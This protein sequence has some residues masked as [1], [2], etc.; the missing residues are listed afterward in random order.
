[1]SAPAEG[2]GAADP[3]EGAPGPTAGDGGAEPAAR[4]EAPA[5]AVDPGAGGAS[6]VAPAPGAGGDPAPP[7]PTPHA[8]T[9]GPAHDPAAPTGAQAPGESGDG[10]AAGRI[11]LVVLVG[12]LA[13]A[14]SG[15]LAG[16]AQVGEVRSTG[17]EAPGA[18]APGDARHASRP[19][20]ATQGREDVAP[21]PRYRDI[22]PRAW[23]PNAGFRTRLPDERPGTPSPT[24]R[25][26]GARSSEG[27]EG[28]DRALALLARAQR[29]AYD[30]APPVIPHPVDPVSVLACNTCHEHGLAV[31]DVIAPR[32]P[33]APYAS[34]TQ[35]HAPGAASEL[36]ATTPGGAPARWSPAPEPAPLG[37]RNAF[38][39]LEGA[40]R[41]RVW[42]GAPPVIPHATWM[43]DD[44]LSCHGPLG[45][46]PLRTSHP[47]R[48]SC[49]QCHAPRASSP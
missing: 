14:L 19:G 40:P 11:G 38:R 22:A 36:A 10:A 37:Q 35:C 18:I 9:P 30:G 21:A 16:M 24:A 13:V 25:A 1:M 39:G 12:A 32:M 44:C 43:R 3:A 47:E 27:R 49:T 15:F 31:G 33:H 23:G 5:S 17:A 8:G 42:P 26:S 20:A 41:E 45:H 48:A 46:A 2:Q 28:E 34:C 7:T 29:R 4:A 6:S